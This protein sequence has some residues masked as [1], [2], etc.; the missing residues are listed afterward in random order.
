MRAGDVVN[1]TD[2]GGSL[3]RQPAVFD[4]RRIITDLFADDFDAGGLG[5]VGQAGQVFVSLRR[6]N[7]HDVFFA[8][9]ARAALDDVEDARILLFDLPDLIKDEQRRRAPAVGSQLA[10]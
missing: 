7:S 5:Y 9:S 2:G 3:Q 8:A 6:Q 1:H 10:D 4:Q